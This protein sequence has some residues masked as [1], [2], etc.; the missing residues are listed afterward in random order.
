MAN[1][2][3]LKPFQ[4]GWKG[5]PGRPQ[6]S[7]NMSTV[8]KELLET[9][10][11]LK[12]AKTGEIIKKTGYEALA[13]TM[14]KTAMQGK[15]E[16]FNAIVDRADGKVVQVNEHTG[17]DGGA[18]INETTFKRSESDQALVDEYYQRRQEQDKMIEIKDNTSH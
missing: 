6:G 7:R 13:Q 4:V 12:D 11:T 5:G 16:A 2:Q 1:E 15:V 17:K 18:I 14:F 10:I 9:E 3:N 8:L